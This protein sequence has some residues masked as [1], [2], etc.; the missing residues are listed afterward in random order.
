[1]LF[2][3]FVLGVIEEEFRLFNKVPEYRFEIETRDGRIFISFGKEQFAFCSNNYE[4]SSIV[5]IALRACNDFS[6]RRGGGQIKLKAL[7]HN[8]S[9]MVIPSPIN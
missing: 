7:Y 8:Y 3:D 4:I 1:M 2:Y 6:E 9:F 5:C